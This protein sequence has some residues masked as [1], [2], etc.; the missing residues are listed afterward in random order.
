MDTTNEPFGGASA[1]SPEPGFRAAPTPP[2]GGWE[3]PEPPKPRRRFGCLAGVM[4]GCLLSVVLA[5]AAMVAVP[6]GMVALAG[7][8]ADK[9]DR[10]ATLA[11]ARGAFRYQLLRGCDTQEGMRAVL[12]LRLRGVITGT[13]ASRWYT[14][15]DSDVA[16][17]EAIEAAIDDPF[18]DGILLDVSSPGGGVTASDAIYHALERF[19]AAK[20]GRKVFVLGGDLV[21]SGAYYLAMQ[22]DWIRLRPTTLVG[23]IGVIVPGVNAAGLAQ[24]LGIADN[25]IASGAS[26]DLGNPLKPINPEHNAILKTVVDAMYARFVGLVAKGR[27]LPEADVRRLADGRV[28]TAQDA[29]NLRLADDVGYEDTLDDKLCELLGCTEEELAVYEPRHAKNTFRAI[30]GELPA[31]VGRDVRQALLE[32][33]AK[34]T[35]Q[36]R[37]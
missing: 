6:V 35:P 32:P 4:C 23:S 8:M 21:A 22:A 28:F 27:K 33:P 34:P 11:E 2:L 7:K 24:R 12:R 3:R 29:V 25:S 1:P 30:L 20:A 16:V 36:Y 31:A 15:A 9:W 26:K 17:L 19:K 37:W 10:D 18:F 13:P 14:E 5:V